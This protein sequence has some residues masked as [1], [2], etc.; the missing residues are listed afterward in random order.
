MSRFQQPTPQQLLS[1]RMPRAAKISRCPTCHGN[2]K[3]EL[4]M[5]TEPCD[6][7]GGTG[8][9]TKSK[10]WEEPCLKCHG[11]GTS[12]Y[13]RQKALPCGQCHGSGTITY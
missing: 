1:Q 3:G 13:C 9:N 10:A 7:C 11:K 8:R 12:P 4:S 6:K 2:G 5:G